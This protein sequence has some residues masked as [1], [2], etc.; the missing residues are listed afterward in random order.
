MLLMRSLKVRNGPDDISKGSQS[1][2]FPEKAAKAAQT[3]PQEV[4]KKKKKKDGKC[5]V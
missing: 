1:F 3:N 2:F 4:S 5:A